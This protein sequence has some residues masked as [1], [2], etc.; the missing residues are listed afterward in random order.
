V[1]LRRFLAVSG[2]SPHVGTE[3]RCAATLTAHSPILICAETYNCPELKKNCID[4]FG[5]GKDFKA[6]A[7]LT[8][9][10]FQLALQFPSI[11]G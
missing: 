8:D 11:F 2:R 4:F 6:K 5:E 10:F 3:E 7:L 1:F 9:G